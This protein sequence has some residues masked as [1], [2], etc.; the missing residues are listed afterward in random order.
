MKRKDFEERLDLYLSG[1]ATEEDID[2]L[3]SY[4][5]SHSDDPEA[6]AVLEMLESGETVDIPEPTPYLK[7]RLFSRLKHRMEVKS[8]KKKFGFI[9]N[10]VRVPSFILVLIFIL[11]LYLSY[12]TIQKNQT[13]SELENATYEVIYTAETEETDESDVYDMEYTEFSE[14]SFVAS[15]FNTININENGGTE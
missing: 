8:K 5:T 1:Q 9:F 15:Y 2:F 14:E 10:P 7:T 12:S 6:F 11:I 4:I 13:I 3:K